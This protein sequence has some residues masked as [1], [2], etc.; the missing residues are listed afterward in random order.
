MSRSQKNVRRAETPSPAPQAS[1][2][3]SYP[4]VT[5]MDSAKNIAGDVTGNP[6]YGEFRVVKE[7][8]D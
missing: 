5:K 8:C 7:C 1:G 3:P 2:K 6:G 4:D